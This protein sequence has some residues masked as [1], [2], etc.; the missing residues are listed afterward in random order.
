MTLLAAMVLAALPIHGTFVPG[1]SLGGVQLGAT[2]AHVQRVW[3]TRHGTCSNCAHATWYFNYVR[4]QPQG[5]GV[6]F[7]SGRVV[8]VFTLWQ[9]SGWRV[10]NGLRLGDSADELRRRIGALARVDCGTY[11]AYVATQRNATTA[12]YVFNSRVW[13][14]GL[15][16]PY[17]S[18]CR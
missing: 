9:P 4:Y 18:A 7:R 1:R 12:Y 17:V 5:A 15:S 13:G 10:A 6:E 16:R 2:P 11:E 14:F 3:G 8:A